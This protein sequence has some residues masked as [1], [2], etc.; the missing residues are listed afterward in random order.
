MSWRD[1]W[2]GDT[3][4]YVN[5]RHKLLHYRL[6]ASGILEAIA[7]LPDPPSPKTA[8]G[9]PAAPPAAG[10]VVLDHGC[11]EALLAG[12]IALRCQRLYLCDAAASVRQKLSARFAALG[13]VAVVSPVEVA[14]IPEA[15]LD[16][17]VANSLVQYLT[18]PEFASALRLW[19]HALKPNGRL[20]LADV[21]PKGSSPAADALALLRFGWQ[22]GFLFAALGGLARTA[23]SDYRK[24]RAELGLAT[25]D[26]HEMIAL[27]GEA[28]FKAERRHPNLGHN[29][30]RM[31]FLATI[32]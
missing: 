16:L 7:E 17:V 24:L 29:Q 13:N 19:R 10:P 11:G 22:G 9:D 27:L 14:D 5:E 25:Y 6:I 28:G 23:L 3:P 21:L 15:S 31:A 8:S 30:A 12:D 4:I 2:D 20:F 1:F 32:G 26:E 18:A